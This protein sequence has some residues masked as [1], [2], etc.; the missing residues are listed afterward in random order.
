[1]KLRLI[2]KMRSYSKSEILLWN[3]DFTLK[4]RF[5]FESEILLWKWD[6]AVEVR[7]LKVRFYC[8]N[9]IWLFKLKISSI[10]L[11]FYPEIKIWQSKIGTS[12]LP[13]SSHIQEIE[14]ID[15]QKK[16]K[17]HFKVTLG[18][19]TIKT[20]WWNRFSKNGEKHCHTF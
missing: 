4:V 18:I 13:Y 7:F 3:P 15:N 10:R 9:D 12:R 1:M 2:L 6:F 5:Y 20:S 16:F 11:R 8:Q 14:I 19:R 17:S